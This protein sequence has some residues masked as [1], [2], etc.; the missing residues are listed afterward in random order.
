MK[1]T[2]LT[3]LYALALADLAGTEQVL[4]IAALLAP[5]VVAIVQAFRRPPRRE[6]RRTRSKL[7]IVLV[8]ALLT[9]IVVLGSGC[10]KSSMAELVRAMGS[11]TNAVTIDV[12]SPWGTVEVRRN[13][14]Q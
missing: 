7:P 6:P 10:V 5:I 1:H 14:P 3:S 9:S 4:R 8:A 11:D 13:A 2:A 12:R